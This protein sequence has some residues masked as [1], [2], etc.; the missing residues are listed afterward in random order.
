MA[1]WDRRPAT[2]RL[3]LRTVY[4]DDVIVCVPMNGV[5]PKMQSACSLIDRDSSRYETRAEPNCFQCVGPVSVC[6]EQKE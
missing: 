4:L 1:V 6:L 2:E 5:F 3:I